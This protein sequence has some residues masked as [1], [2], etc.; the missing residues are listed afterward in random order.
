MSLL[1]H[2]SPQLDDAALGEDFTK[3]SSHVVWATIVAAVVVSA[4]I[5]IYVISGEKPPPATGEIEQV[6]VHPQHSETSGFDA[7]GAPM[8]KETHD[9]VYV[10]A[11]VKLHNQ[12]KIPLFLRN[13]M[14]NAKLPD[15]IHSS[16]AATAADYDRV[17]LAYPS[18][19]VPH[20]KGLSLQTTIDPG[21]TVEGTIVS[22]FRLTKEQ[23]A[24]GKDLSFTF[25]LQYQPSLVLAPHGAVIDR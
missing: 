18:M 9:Q 5:A 2:D 17:F 16:Y 1:Q 22:A 10:F 20:G 8:F 25:G 19:P 11:L 23:W 13:A 12:S 6:W 14:V 3:G 4:A 7:N 21:Q 15:G 24:A